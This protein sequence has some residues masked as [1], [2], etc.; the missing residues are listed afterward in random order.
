MPCEDIARGVGEGVEPWHRRTEVADVGLDDF[1]NRRVLI[2]R[3][4]VA[5]L[6][7]KAAKFSGR[8]SLRYVRLN[9]CFSSGNSRY[10]RSVVSLANA[11]WKRAPASDRARTKLAVSATAMRRSSI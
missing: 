10:S 5:E 4:F 3:Q 6:P 1:A 11:I 7:P 2:R 9:S 8:W